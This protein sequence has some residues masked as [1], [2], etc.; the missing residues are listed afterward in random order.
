MTSEKITEYKEELQAKD[1][2]LEQAKAECD[3]LR[4]EVEQRKGKS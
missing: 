2:A 1:K 3:R 4:A